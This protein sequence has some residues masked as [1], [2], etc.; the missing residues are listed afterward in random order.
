MFSLANYL[1]VF[2]VTEDKLKK[3]MKILYCEL[4]TFYATSGLNSFVTTK[5]KRCQ[6]NLKETN[7]KEIDDEKIFTVASIDFLIKGGDYFA[8][9][10]K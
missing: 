10:V 5:P 2:E 1:V 6:V 8:N 4:K 7:G 9:V 3:I